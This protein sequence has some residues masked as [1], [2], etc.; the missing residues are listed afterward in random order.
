VYVDSLGTQFGNHGYN[1][2]LKAAAHYNLQQSFSCLRVAF[3][4]IF[5]KRTVCDRQ[6]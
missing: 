2:I 3:K 1:G 5:W 6:Y 4:R